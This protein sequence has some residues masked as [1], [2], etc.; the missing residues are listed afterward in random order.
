MA[1]ERWRSWAAR[2]AVV[3]AGALVAVS[4][5]RLWAYANRDNPLVIENPDVARV[6]NAACAALRDEA[7]AAAVATTAPIA[8]RVGAI[9]AQNDAV[10]QLVA[11]VDRL[12]APEAIAQDRP[13]ATWLADWQRL[14]VVRDGYARSLASGHPTPM[15]MP[16]IDGRSLQERLNDVGLNC[17]VPPVLLAP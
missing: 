15:A 1:G 10:T 16:T 3:V 13:A 8:Q 9:N 12:V 5:M 7:A 4:L 17:R 2:A 11:T 6:A 14:V